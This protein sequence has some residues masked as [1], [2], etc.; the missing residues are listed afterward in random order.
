MKQIAPAFL[1]LSCLLLSLGLVSLPVK[2]S[3]SA[4]T[5]ADA[6][7]TIIHANSWNPTTPNSEVPHYATVF[8]V[9]SPSYYQ[10][11][12]QISSSESMS[13]PWP[14][15]PVNVLELKRMAILDGE[16]SAV[17]DT[18]VDSYLS[19][20][21]MLGYLPSI[22]SGWCYYDRYTADAYDWAPSSLASKW[23]KAAAGQQIV[24]IVGTDVNGPNTGIGY[25][26]T[27]AW[28]P[29]YR[30]YDDTAT[31]IEWLLQ[32]GG[33]SYMSTCD[34]IWNFQQS[35]FWNGQYYGYSGQSGME[36][37]VGPFAIIEGR[38]LATKGELSTYGSRIV[39]DLNQ[40][41]L[42]NGYSSPLW[43]HYSLNHVPAYDERRLENAVDAWAAMQ[44]W[45]PLMTPAMQATFQTMGAVGWKGILDVSGD[46]DSSSNMFRVWG[47]PV[48]T[49]MAATGDGLMLLFLNGIVPKTGS[50]AVPLNDERYED[51][52]GWSPAE[53][54]RFNYGSRSIEIPVNAGEIDFIFGSGTASYN[55]PST[56]VYTVQFSSD[57]NTVTSA[58]MVGS[59]DPQFKYISGGSGP[60][61]P[62]PQGHGSIQVT[63]TNNGQAVSFQTWYDST[64]QVF[65]PTT[66]YAFSNVPLG[67][68]TVYGT[69]NGITK[70]AVVSVSNGQTATC[71]LDF[72]SP[73][74]ENNVRPHWWPAPLPWP[75]PAPLSTIVTSPLYMFAGVGAGLVL[76]VAVAASVSRYKPAGFP[77]RRRRARYGDKNY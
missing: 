32:L 30:Y 28:R 19:S 68:H 2:A 50:L 20:A 5:L 13:G 17:S 34:L 73:P 65:S 26:A 1:L 51:T 8:S 74:L 58:S 53:M 37:E 67:S 75:L 77:P 24:S 40:K 10:T 61:P 31:T 42:I 27:Q 6:M 15:N 48:G 47:Y 49:D 7:G 3:L 72:S 55:F 56:G 22:Y 16:S 21:T 66:G 4:G 33:T 70:S 23:N 39:S 43:N 69:Y 46:F 52:V 12:A 44:A 38:Y 59:L 63:G 25:S 11:A 36:T 54:F 14:T 71:A 76:I 18:T 29:Y 60:P 57:W 64:S 62:P 35:Y 45:Y 41:L 9:G